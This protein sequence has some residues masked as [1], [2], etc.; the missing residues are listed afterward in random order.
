MTLLLTILAVLTSISFSTST[1]ISAAGLHNIELCPLD[2]LPCT[3]SG[4]VI[5]PDSHEVPSASSASSVSSASEKSSASSIS[6]PKPPRPPP[7]TAVPIIYPTSSTSSTTGIE[8]GTK[9]PITA[10][11]TTTLVVTITQTVPAVTVTKIAPSPVYETVPSGAEIFPSLSSDLGSESSW[12]YSPLPPTYT[13]EPGDDETS[14]YRSSAPSSSSSSTSSKKSSTSS[15]ST[16]QSITT[17]TSSTPTPTT[18]PKTSPTTLKST[19]TNS[20]CTS[21]LTYTVPTRSSASPPDSTYTVYTSTT[22]VRSWVNC[23][24]C[25]NLAVVTNSPASERPLTFTKVITAAS[26]TWTIAFHC[27]TGGAEKIVTPTYSTAVSP[28]TTIT[29]TGLFG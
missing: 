14:T 24:G 8:F 7:P 3:Q 4:V 10:S 6:T 13:S 1:P 26:A 28:F 27:T 11:R 19:M 21:T 5:N 20:L 23:G 16:S 9:G 22:T 18:T 17:K 29:M 15:P 12:L 2:G 25:T